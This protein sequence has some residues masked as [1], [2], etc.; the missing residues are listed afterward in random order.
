MKVIFLDIDGVLNVIPTEWDDYGEI[1]HTPLVNN[2]NHIIES[3]GAKLV[4]SSSCRS[5]GLVFLRNMWLTRNLPGEIYDITPI[6]SRVKRG[7]E[8][9]K[10]LNQHPEVKNYVILD[11][12]IDML[13]EQKNNFVQTSEN[14][15]HDDC[16]DIGYGLTKTCA[17]KAIK[18]LN[19]EL[20]YQLITLKSNESFLHLCNNNYILTNKIT[21]YDSNFNN[22]PVNI[23]IISNEN[24]V[25]GDY[26]LYQNGEIVGRAYDG[27]L[28]TYLGKVVATSDPFLIKN[29]I[30][31]LEK[32]FL[33]FF[34]KKQGNF[35]GS[36]IYE[37]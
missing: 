37:N 1:F 36:E 31:G 13:P 23:Y 9:K 33:E 12:D 15:D 7:Y 18:I 8:I 17:E 29:R 10:W 24:I 30:K 25:D 21:E 34:V 19:K 3:T 32:E 27:C 26:V 2:L 6:I 16:I 28:E 4:I 14:I 22:Q 35:M 20:I 5:S 11:D